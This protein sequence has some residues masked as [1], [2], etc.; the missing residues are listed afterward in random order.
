MISIAVMLLVVSISIRILPIVYVTTLGKEGIAS[1]EEIKYV[2]QCNSTHLPPD[3]HLHH[4]NA[5]CN[6]ASAAQELHSHINHKLDVYQ[7]LINNHKPT[8]LQ[9]NIPKQFF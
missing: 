5:I 1:K 7:H 3:V 8:G 4:C 2:L 9:M 6:A